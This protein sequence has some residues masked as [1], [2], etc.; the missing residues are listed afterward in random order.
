MAVSRLWRAGLRTLLRTQ[1]GEDG[2]WQENV[3]GRLHRLHDE[4]GRA[5]RFKVWLRDESWRTTKVTTVSAE[6][7]DDLPREVATQEPHY[8][9]VLDAAAPWPEG[10]PEPKATYAEIW[11]GV[12]NPA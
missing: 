4:R 10:T 1:G 2:A 5:M 11:E 12:S 8:R 9:W 7:A 6:S 3:V